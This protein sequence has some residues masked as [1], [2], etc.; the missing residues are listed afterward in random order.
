MMGAAGLQ[1]KRP[2]FQRPGT[3]RVTCPRGAGEALAGEIGEAGFAQSLRS[4][5]DAVELAGTLADCMRLNLTLRTANRVFYRLCTFSADTPDDLYRGVYRFAWEDFLTPAGSF[6]VHGFVRSASI[7]D[8]RFAN[9]KVKDAIADRFTARFGRRPDSGPERTGFVVFLHWV[10]GRVQLYID[11]S[12]E[13]LSRHG[14]RQVP[15]QAPLQESLAAALVLS[16]GWDRCSSLVNP[17][18]GSGTLAIE[19]ALAAAGKAPGLARKRFG[20]MHVAGYDR[21]RWEKMRS[22]ARRQGAGS[23]RGRILAS[24]IRKEAVA[25]ARQHAAAAGVE[26]WIAFSVCDFKETEVPDPPGVVLLNPPYGERLGD[27]KALADLYPAIGDFFKQRCTG[28]RG[29]VFTGNAN[30]AKRIGL[31]ARR[32][33]VFFNGPIE[34]RLL[35]YDLYQGSRRRPD[36]D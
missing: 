18:C 19:A 4:T 10:K 12:G 24:D 8:G 7:N 11:T 27:E 15:L 14:Y 3:I 26:P 1:T 30:L 25:A 22:E 33:Q 6:S 17:M 16:T 23:P 21:R 29:F 34:C 2:V 9:L 35:A 13:T 28:Y 5:T 36:P 31:R 32:R 20:F